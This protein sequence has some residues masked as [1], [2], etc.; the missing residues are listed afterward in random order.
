M[1]LLLLLLL[2]LCHVENG[3]VIY[4]FTSVKPSSST[5][6]VQHNSSRSL[7]SLLNLYSRF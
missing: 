4:Q 6:A 3:K 1:L 2:W 7:R 5:S